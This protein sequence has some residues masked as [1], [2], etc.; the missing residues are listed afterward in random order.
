MLRSV[1]EKGRA[2]GGQDDAGVLFLQSISDL[3]RTNSQMLQTVELVAAF[4]TSS[5]GI[6]YYGSSMN[7][8]KV[9]AEAGLS[10]YKPLLVI[11]TNAIEAE[12]TNI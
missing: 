8:P 9:I 10:Y 2:F 7:K 12:P 4:T 3:T 6:A 5:F 1:F 11:F